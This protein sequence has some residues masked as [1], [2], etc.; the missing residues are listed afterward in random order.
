M[1]SSSPWP[2]VSSPITA[3]ALVSS[4]SP[5]RRPPQQQQQLND[6]DERPRHAKP[7][8]QQFR[9]DP[10]F[11]HGPSEAQNQGRQANAYPQTHNPE[12][13]SPE[14]FVFGV[15]EV[16]QD[17]P[18]ALF[19]SFAIWQELREGEMDQAVQRLQCGVV[20]HAGHNAV[21]APQHQYMVQIG[22]AAAD[23]GLQR[24]RLR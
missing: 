11:S 12:Q 1:S 10:G 24:P 20:V 2:D 21:A 5:Q 17:M 4:H 23:V 18:G 7:I 9:S 15:E 14:G 13:S 19:G 8:G 6:V 22:L 3:R 16:A